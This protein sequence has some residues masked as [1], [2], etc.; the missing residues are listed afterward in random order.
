[1]KKIFCPTFLYNGFE[2]DG[3]KKGQAVCV[4]DTTITDIGP[5]EDLLSHYP[6]ASVVAYEDSLMV[7][8][9][10]N[11]HDHGRALSCAAFGVKDQPLELWIPDLY[12]ITLPMRAAIIYEGLRLAQTGV[13]TVVHC[14]NYGDPACALQELE[15]VAFGYNQ[16][17]VKVVLCVPFYDQNAIIYD[18]RD[19]FIAALP[20]N[21]QAEFKSR[22]TDSP[23]SLSE[24]FSLIKQLSNN[25]KTQIDK[26]MVSIQLQPVGGQWCSDEA[27]IAIK[28]YSR[29]HKIPVHMHLLETRYQSIYAQRRFGCSMVQ[30]LKDIDFLDQDVS[31]AH[32]VWATDQD[33]DIVQESGAKIVTNPSSNL[34]L[35]SGIAKLH[36]MIDKNCICALGTDGCSLDD[37]QDY[38]R[39]MRVALLNPS[40]SGINTSLSARHILKMATQG[41]AAVANHA[42]S[43]GAITKGAPADFIIF[44][45]SAMKAPWSISDIDPI[46]TLLRSGTKHNIISAYT[47]GLETVNHG[48][49]QLYDYSTAAQQLKEEIENMRKTSPTANPDVDAALKSYIHA[50]YSGW[51]L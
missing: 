47:N 40:R 21:L 33:L 22:I 37:D 27:L 30:H 3:T 45:L 18:E 29:A 2:H 20:G 51:D 16:T 48:K 50:F 38:V 25:L 34:R 44:D 24:Y 36:D 19:K 15:D 11:A 14:H 17:G 6:D 5:I 9:F 46:E 49:T 41:G 39:E 28:N 32:M 23:Y 13:S 1:M 4:T 12:K 7:P 35:K 26:G 42:L 31:F 10:V 8:S 43:S